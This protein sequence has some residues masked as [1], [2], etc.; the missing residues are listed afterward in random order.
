MNICTQCLCKFS[1]FCLT[2]HLGES[3]SGSSH[4]LLE[5]S[6]SS[7]PCKDLSCRWQWQYF[8]SAGILT[9]SV[10]SFI[11]LEEKLFRVLFHHF[12]YLFWGVKKSVPSQLIFMTQSSFHF[13]K[14]HSNLAS[15][16]EFNKWLLKSVFWF[17]LKCM[18]F[19]SLNPAPSL[20]WS[21]SIDFGE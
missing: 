4:L 13:R 19:D 20:Y 7:G 10:H 11:K 15:P 18:K 21:S 9:V 1:S 14:R 8:N 6:L 17:R 16:H 2:A 12:W 5:N 3:L